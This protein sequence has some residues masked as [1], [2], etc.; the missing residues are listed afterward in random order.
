MSLHDEPSG[1]RNGDMHQRQ[2]AEPVPPAVTLQELFDSRFAPTVLA[3][4]FCHKRTDRWTGQ[5][6]RFLAQG[7]SALGSR[8][9]IEELL[10]IGSA[11]ERPCEEHAQPQPRNSAEGR[12]SPFELR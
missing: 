10:R 6:T 7:H 11:T 4:I 2:H 3:G 12:L 1:R 5:P 9:E 8:R